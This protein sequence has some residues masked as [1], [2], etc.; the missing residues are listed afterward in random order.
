MKT[1]LTLA[2]VPA[3][4]DEKLNVC[5]KLTTATLQD[6][7]EERR[8]IAIRNQHEQIYRLIGSSDVRETLTV[9]RKLQRLRCVGATLTTAESS[10]YAHVIYSLPKAYLTEAAELEEADDVIARNE[11]DQGKDLMSIFFRGHSYQ[12]QPRQHR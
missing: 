10:H 1:T 4:F 3:A 7:L 2:E 8:I 9:I 6:V 11:A 12:H 5:L